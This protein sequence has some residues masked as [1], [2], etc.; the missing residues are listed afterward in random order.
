MALDLMRTA[1]CSQQIERHGWS[2]SYTL[3]K[4]GSS[5]R[6]DIHI[7]DPRDG[8]KLYSII[9]FKRKVGLVDPAE[10]TRIIRRG[11]PRHRRGT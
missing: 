6:G 2:I 11:Q 9:A 8:A 3:R 7:V 4:P 1:P 10:P 5:M